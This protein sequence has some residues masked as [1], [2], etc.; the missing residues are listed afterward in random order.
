MKLLLLDHNLSPK[1]IRRL[2]DI[3]P[4]AV[5]VSHLGLDSESDKV[6]W[7][8]A[9][10]SDLVIVT[11]DADFGD[12]SVVWG[13]P[14]QIVWIRRGN[15]STDDI[16]MILRDNFGTIVEFCNDN[17]VGMLLVLSR[18]PIPRQSIYPRRHLRQHAECLLPGCGAGQVAS[19]TPPRA[20]AA[21]IRV[22]GSY[23]E[24]HYNTTHDIVV[25]RPRH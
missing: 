17:S 6:I 13:I 12:F 20:S 1:L 2:A 23:H 9:R 22:F 5:H 15:C 3:Y 25:S 10:D 11:K 7:E 18:Y 14:P 8:Y 4:D 24:G 19:P 16:E 21:S